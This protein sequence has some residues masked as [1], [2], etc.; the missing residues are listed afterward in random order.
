VSVAGLGIAMILAPGGEFEMGSDL[1]PNAVPAH[2]IKV[3]PF[4]LGKFELTQVEWRAVMGSNPS[5]QQGASFPD[6]DRMPVEQVSWQDCQA[7]VRKL[8]ERVPGGGFRLPTEAEWE[9]AAQAPE[10]YHHTES[11]APKAVGKGKPNRFGFYDMLG[12]VSEWCSS[13]YRPYPYSAR[14]GRED[15]GAPGLRVLRGG[16]FADLERWVDSSARHSDRS[17]R[18]LR[19]NGFRLAR[20]IPGED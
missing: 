9:Y 14:D 8:N 6:A 18:R 4:Y 12:N 16:G 1:F 13:L 19:W 11:A 17:D 3:K 20:N 15:P 7:F 5:Y 10:Q 2:T